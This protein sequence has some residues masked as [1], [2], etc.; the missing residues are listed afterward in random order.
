MGS[1][2]PQVQRELPARK[3]HRDRQ[4]HQDKEDHG[5][6]QVLQDLWGQQDPGETLG[7]WEVQ[8]QQGL[9]GKLELQEL[10]DKEVS[11]DP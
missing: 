8:V 11:R 5:V 4:E 1:Q 10:L 7:H 9:L 2:D 3:D 6:N